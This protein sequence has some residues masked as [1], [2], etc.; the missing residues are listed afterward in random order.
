M[1]E[2]SANCGE[3]AAD[4]GRN[5]LSHV[6]KITE[7]T[8]LPKCSRFLEVPYILVQVNEIGIDAANDIA[9]ISHN[10]IG[11]RS[12]RQ[13]FLLKGER[14]K[15]EYAVAL[16][17]AYCLSREADVVYYFRNEDFKWK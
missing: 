5:A 17:S 11:L 16:A 3:Q 6:K 10:R 2:V 15:F 13:E 8:G 12:D 4:I 9:I 14:M 1:A 7:T